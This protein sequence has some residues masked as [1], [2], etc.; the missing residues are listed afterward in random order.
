MIAITY[1]VSGVLLAISGYFFS[2]GVFTAQTQTIAWMVIFFFASPAAGA[3]YLTV[4]E[5]FRS[6]SAR[7]RLRCSTRSAPRSAVS[8]GPL[9]SAC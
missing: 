8:P 1:G 5:T 4:S 7:W 6:R 2:I 9:C 3:A